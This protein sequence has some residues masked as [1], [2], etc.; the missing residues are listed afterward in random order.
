MHRHGPGTPVVCNRGWSIGNPAACVEGSK[1][2]EVSFQLVL[3]LSGNCVACGSM[4]KQ[5]R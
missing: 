5:H 2:N 3:L 4:V 1:M